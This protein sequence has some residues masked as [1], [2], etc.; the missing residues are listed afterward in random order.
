MCPLGAWPYHHKPPFQ[1][2]PYYLPSYVARGICAGVENGIYSSRS[3]CSL[4]KD[5]ES[6]T[7][8]QT[9]QLTIWES[10]PVNGRK[11]FYTLETA[12]GPP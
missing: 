8:Q 1:S 7:H 6:E 4:H 5:R 11:I 12:T 3:G 10:S 9:S 2:Y